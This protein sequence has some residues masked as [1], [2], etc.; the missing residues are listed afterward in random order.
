MALIGRGGRHAR[1]SIVFS[2]SQAP[3]RI[4]GLFIIRHACCLRVLGDVFLLRGPPLKPSSER[5]ALIASLEGLKKAVND[6]ID[7]DI[8]D[9]AWALW[10]VHQIEDARFLAD[11]L[12]APLAVVE[13]AISTV[14]AAKNLQDVIR[15]LGN[16]SSPLGFVAYAMGLSQ[17][18]EAG[19][20]LQMAWD[21]PAY[22]SAVRALY[23]EVGKAQSLQ[24]A[25]YTIRMLLNPLKGSGGSLSIRAP[26]QARVRGISDFVHRPG[27]MRRFVAEALNQLARELATGTFELGPPLVNALRG[28]VEQATAAIKRSKSAPLDVSPAPGSDR[29]QDISLGAIAGFRTT[30]VDLLAAYDRKMYRESVSVKVKAVK[31]AGRALILHQTFELGGRWGIVERSFS[32][33]VREQLAAV[34]QQMVLALGP[35]LTNAWLVVEELRRVNPLRT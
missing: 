29:L 14:A 22:S 24:G 7:S 30:E 12:G 2:P 26:D 16:A 27:D 5:E 34:P 15:G 13:Q 1:A 21:G 32:S 9:V 17:L 10:S 11:L 33:N 35:E 18:N 19:T 20:N 4:W 25:A 3:Q 23:D 28:R 31:A 8:D 6:K